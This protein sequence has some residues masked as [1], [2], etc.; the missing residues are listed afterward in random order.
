MSNGRKKTTASSREIALTVRGVSKT[1]CSQS[2]EKVSALE[3]LDLTVRRGEFVVLIGP[4]GCGK[5]TLLNM[6]AGLAK[7]DRGEINFNTTPSSDDNI[8]YVFQ[9]YTLFPWRTLL[10]NV[11]FGLQMRGV[12]RRERKE[13]ARAILDQVGLSDF[14]NAFP[15]ETSGGMRQRAAIAQALAFNPEF[16]LMDEPFG[17]LDDATRT[18]LQ[19]LLVRLCQASGAAVLFVTHNI[20]EAVMTA[21]RILVFSERP[22]RIIEEVS[23]PLPRPRNPLDPRFMELFVRIRNAVH[24]GSN[25]PTP[26]RDSG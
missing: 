23:V 25:A 17:A 14:E 11:S 19:R 12:A 18:E 20:D 24:A 4:T 8:A 1:F 16:L 10:N 21:D 13:R 15:H 26:Y 5:S 3:G 22:G 2:G 9:H 7:P 6:L